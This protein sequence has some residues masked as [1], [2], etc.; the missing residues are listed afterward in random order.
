MLSL[1]LSSMI[2]SVVSETVSIVE[3]IDCYLSYIILLRYRNSI[4]GV[5]AHH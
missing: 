3:I 4:E 1:L 5:S 2:I